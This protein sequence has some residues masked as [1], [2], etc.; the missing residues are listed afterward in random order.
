LSRRRRARGVHEGEGITL[1]LHGRSD[2]PFG[3][4]GV[5]HYRDALGEIGAGRGWT[6]SRNECLAALIIANGKP[7]EKNRVAVE[8]G[9]VK[10]GYCPSYLA[11]QFLEW[12]D[13]WHYSRAIVWCRA[14]LVTG[15]EG[16]AV[17]LDIE[18]PFKATRL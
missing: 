16:P 11:T 14:L 9:G 2:Y 13:Y 4:I 3:V 12:I 6:P 15:D 18:L 10:V 8:M 17:K 5:S 7:Y 1:F